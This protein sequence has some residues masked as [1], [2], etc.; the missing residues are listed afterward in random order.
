MNNHEFE[1]FG[2]DKKTP[3]NEEFMTQSRQVPDLD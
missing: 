2:P 3:G 1:K